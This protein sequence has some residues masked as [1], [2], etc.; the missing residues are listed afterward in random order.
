ME[1]PCPNRILQI[2]IRFHYPVKKGQP[3]GFAGV[4]AKIFL[5]SPH[6]KEII[7]ITGD[8]KNFFLSRMYRNKSDVKYETSLK[9]LKTDDGKLVPKNYR[10][11]K[12][13]TY[14]VKLPV[15]ILNHLQEYIVDIIQFWFNQG[16]LTN[17]LSI[18]VDGKKINAWEPV[19]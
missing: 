17:K 10:Q 15:L 2:I 8:G 3:I 18:S 11:L 13:T 9:N 12:G 7:T 16:I 1:I 19:G 5:G 14:K 6:G 4:G